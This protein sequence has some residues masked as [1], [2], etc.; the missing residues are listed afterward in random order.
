MPAAILWNKAAYKCVR[1][2]SQKSCRIRYEKTYELFFSDSGQ[3]TTRPLGGVCMLTTY[4]ASVASHVA[5]DRLL[6]EWWSISRILA[7]HTSRPAD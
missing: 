1:D 2:Q 3:N 4:Q 5:Q 7:I 6:S